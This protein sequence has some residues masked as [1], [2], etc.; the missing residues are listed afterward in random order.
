M[1]A[2][3]VFRQ[4]AYLEL[5]TTLYTLVSEGNLK[6]EWRVFPLVN[7]VAGIPAKVDVD[8]IMLFVIK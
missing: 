4:F 1:Y 6:T 2:F 3:T 8:V 5:G 7:S